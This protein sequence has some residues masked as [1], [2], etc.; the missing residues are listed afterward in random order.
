MPDIRTLEP[1][2][3]NH[4]LAGALKEYTEFKAPEWSLFVKTAA[5]KQRP[6]AE[7]D[8]WY[9][10]AVSIL[11]Q[12]YIYNIIGVNRL[13][14]RYG[15][16]KNRGMKPANFRPAGGKMI[17]LILQQAEGAGLLEKAK[18]KKAGRQLTAQGKKLLEGVK[19]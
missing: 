2:K 11:R 3:Y 4:A 7:V 13:R 18:G 9:K 14:T 19:V 12:A 15:G 10:R 16:R 8:F 5:H 1:G 17:R 6:T